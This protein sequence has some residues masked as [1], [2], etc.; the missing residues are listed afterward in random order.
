MRTLIIRSFAAH[1]GRLTLTV[2]AVTLSVSFVSASFILADSLRSTFGDVAA[3]IYGGVD[4]EIRAGVGD[5]DQVATGARFSESD[6][7]AAAAVDGVTDFTPVLEAENVLFTVDADGEVLR[8]TGPP[9]L[10]FSTMGYSTASPFTIVSGKPP[11]AGDVMLDTAQVEAL[12]AS[13]G[14]PI[15]IGDDVSVSTPNGIE[16]FRLSGTHVFGDGD[17]GVSPYFLLFERTTMQRLVDATGLVDSASIVVDAGA[18][19]D[20]VMRSLAAAL[21]S[22]LTI[23]DQSQLVAEQNDEFGAVIDII[24]TALLVFAGITLFVSTFVIANTFAVLVGQQRREI[25]LLRAVGASPRQATSIVVAE[26]GL[27]GLVAAGLGLGG[28]YLVAE[29]IK[30]L[31]AAVANGGFPEGPTLFLPRTIA[32]AI[33]LGVGVT[34]L[35]ALV[36]ALRAGRV[37]PLVAMRPIE[38]P[39]ASGTPASRAL[40]R[41]ASIAVGRFGASGQM[42]AM[43]VARNPRRVASTAMSMVV[44]LAVI[45]SMSVIAASYRAT[46][47]DAASRSFDADLVI[48]GDD[49]V[50][51]PHA[52]MVEIADLPEVSAAAGYGVTEVRHDGVTTEIA[53]FASDIANDVVRFDSMDGRTSALASTETVITDDF[54]ADHSYS[55]GAVVPVE[56]SDGAIVDLSVVGIVESSA[57]LGADVLVDADLVAAHARNVDANFGAVRFAADSDSSAA[58]AAVEGTLAGH[59]QLD[60]ATVDEHVAAQEAQAQQL[61]TLANGLL[62]LT[63]V[64]ALTGIA[65]TVALSM[66]ERQREVGLL[67]AVGMTRRQL[68]AMVR[69]EAFVLSL[70]GATA[71][72]TIGVVGALIAIPFLPDALVGQL[73][74]PVGS[75]AVSVALSVAFGVLAATL[76]ARRTARLD[77]VDAVS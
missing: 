70:V 26:A 57:V 61:L 40:R 20:D 64:V 41:F 49:G 77:V 68:R 6:L 1:R 60:V 52:A 10:S 15:A 42:A 46:V 75:L 23:V 8:Q 12:A 28:G 14:A 72:V 2:L 5:F 30:A 62:A 19:R 69:N 48:T 58:M 21:P 67:R 4:A 43:S 39:A 44:G 29:G 13:A 24:Q 9:T 38:G 45:A 51:V 17:V 53:G 18:D 66:L 34:V 63:I 25:G 3:N 11:S 65:N 31:V 36:P 16:T 35:S 56:F 37:S 73:R 59:P 33:V 54:A 22:G 32:I 27:V 7:L 47:S 55:V 74:I 76:P 71:G 50:T